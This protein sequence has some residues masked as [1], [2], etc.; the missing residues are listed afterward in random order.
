[1]FTSLL[2]CITGLFSV[3]LI[4]ISSD[5]MEFKFS[6]HTTVDKLNPGRVAIA[7]SISKILASV[8]TYPHEVCSAGSLD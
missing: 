5:C 7:S 4:P 2:V 8:I 3:F 1:M 6:D